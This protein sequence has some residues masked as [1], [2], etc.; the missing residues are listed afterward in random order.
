[1][2][3]LSMFLFEFHLVPPW[4]GVRA[5][6]C[7]QQRKHG[8]DFYKRERSLYGRAERKH[9]VSQQER[10][11][12]SWRI[13]C[14][15]RKPTAFM[16]GTGVQLKSERKMSAQYINTVTVKEAFLWA[17]QLSCVV[18][19]NNSA[20]DFDRCYVCAEGL[21]AVNAPQSLLNHTYIHREA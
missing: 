10:A 2:N 12:Q 14:P 16:K 6:K 15:T 13:F 7:W 1:M 20:G 21:L 11:T 8:L 4:R 9:L 19:M 5:H 17:P 3:N 18:Y